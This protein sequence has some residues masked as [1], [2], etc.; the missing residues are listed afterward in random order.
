M[1]YCI[2]AGTALIL[3]VCLVF[4]VMIFGEL[5][6]LGLT[7]SLQ[8]AAPPRMCFLC[9]AGVSVVLRLG[10]C[11]DGERVAFAGNLAQCSVLVFR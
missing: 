5:R 8:N 9:C 7:Q 10:S 1:R 2:V 6:V 4:H 3:Q 11:A